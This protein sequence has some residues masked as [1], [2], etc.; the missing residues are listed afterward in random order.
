[1][2]LLL[3]NTIKDSNYYKADLL[4]KWYEFKGL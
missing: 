2:D 1:L 4:I 3:F